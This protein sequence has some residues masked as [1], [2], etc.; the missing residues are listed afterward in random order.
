MGINTILWKLNFYKKKICECK[1][2]MT[3][4][5]ETLMNMMINLI[6][7]LGYWGVFI[8]MLIKIPSEVILPLAGF[9]VLQGKMTIWGITL[10]AALAD[11]VGALFLY[12]ISLKGG[13]PLLDK[14]GKYF[15]ISP[16]KLDRGDKWFVKYGDETV[17]ISRCIPM[18]TELVSITAGVSKMDLKKYIIY[19]YLGALPFD[20]G[21]VYLGFILG[22][23]W[24]IVETYS[25]QLDIIFYIGIIAVVAFIV[26][27]IIQTRDDG[28]LI[29]KN[30]NQ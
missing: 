16:S 13:R 29:V 28:N 30:T 19:T 24:N 14:Y 9:A 12:F 22:P 6:Y 23:H 1:K 7:N 25:S 17:L 26:Y 15:S 27:K 3:A 21:L 4:I 10:V 20:F 11:V 8:G 18:I 2:I 5:I